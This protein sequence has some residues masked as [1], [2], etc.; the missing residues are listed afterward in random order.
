MES[1]ALLSGF[2]PQTRL[3]FDSF[4]VMPFKVVHHVPCYGF[5]FEA[6]GT[7][8]VHFTDSAPEFSSLQRHMA[9]GADVVIFHTPTFEAHH[10]HTSV[11]DIISLVRDWTLKKVVITHINHNNLTHE[12]LLDKVAVYGITVAYDGLTLEV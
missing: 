8:V 4:W 6:E 12:E 11:Q 5:V 2:Y 3:H 9:E 1:R 10:S 7:R